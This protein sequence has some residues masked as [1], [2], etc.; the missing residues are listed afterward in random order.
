MLE[1]MGLDVS[2]GKGGGVS[3]SVSVGV[4][5]AVAVADGMVAVSVTEI[6]A[7]FVATA[8]GGIGAE[9]KVQA[10]EVRAHKIEKINGRFIDN[11]RF[12]SRI[13]YPKNSNR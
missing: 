11:D 12:L 10:K 2:V 6:N 8:V 1:G 5:E 13:I 3:V 4:T 7:V 9:V